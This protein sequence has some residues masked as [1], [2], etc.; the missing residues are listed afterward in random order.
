MVA[1]AVPLILQIVPPNWVYGFRTS[2]T[3]SSDEVWY[4]ANRIAGF[5][6]FG[7]GVAWTT[8]AVVLPLTWR[9]DRAL[10]W[11]VGLGVSF[12]M[13]ALVVTF[14]LVYREG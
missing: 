8:V 6:I 3:M 11:V 10:W 4:R 13:V 9:S 2:Y 7:A 1:I 14:V 12:L 5:A